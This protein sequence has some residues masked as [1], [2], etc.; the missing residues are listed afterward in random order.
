M[1]DFIGFRSTTM[2]GKQDLPFGGSVIKIPQNNNI[3]NE[4][5]KLPIRPST[6]SLEQNL[7]DSLNT[8][9][10]YTTTEKYNSTTLY[11]APKDK[12]EPNVAE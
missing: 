8:I 9:N 10:Q 5:N 12:D 2:I 1:A 11:T 6:S 7:L 3:I 4:Y